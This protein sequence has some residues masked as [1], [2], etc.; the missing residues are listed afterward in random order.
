MR[1]NTMLDL[2]D[3]VISFLQE[4]RFFRGHYLFTG[5]KNEY[6]KIAFIVSFPEVWNSLRSIY[7]AALSMN[8]DTLVVCVP[9]KDSKGDYLLKNDAYEFLSKNNVN[10]IIDGRLNDKEWFDLKN[11]NA[12]YV[13]FSRPYKSEYP[14]CYSPYALSRY[15][16]VCYV[17]YGFI[18]SEGHI[19][20]SVYNWPFILGTAFS[21]VQ[22]DNQL[23]KCKKKFFKQFIS[24][25]NS[26]VN[27]GHPRFD[28]LGKC[29]TTDTSKF[30]IA[31]MPR[32]EFIEKEG[33][34]VSHFLAYF[35]DWYSYADSNKDVDFILRPHPLMFS[36]MV[37]E[38]IIDQSAVDGIIRKIDC[39]PNVFLDMGG[40]Y[41]P[42]L[43]KANV[44]IADLTSLIVEFFV[45]GKPIIYCDKAD[46]F[47]NDAKMIDEV[48][49]HANTWT[50]VCDCLEKLKNHIDEK[51]ND[52][53]RVINGLIPSNAGDIGKSIVNYL[54]N[55]SRHKGDKDIWDKIE[56]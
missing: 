32:W 12:D 47:N 1:E 20:E 26:F 48:L 3:Y 38:N 24:H 19:F 42:T 18:M 11:W 46:M 53:A 40:D 54:L 14:E 43:K 23:E 39:A 10:N 36:T 5:Q 56:G 22:S 35:D 41:L 30:T 13:F 50:D 29:S 16:S 27:L 17:P 33:Q 2:K 55:E 37:K 25:R 51:K 9:K 7:E 6:P 21:F 52:R 15:T 45:T 34:K 8:L 28:L 31:W 44:L 4:I 49:Y